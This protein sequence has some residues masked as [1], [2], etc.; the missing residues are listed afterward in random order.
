[1][2]LSREWGSEFLN[3]VET[4]RLDSSSLKI[5]PRRPLAVKKAQLFSFENAMETTLIGWGYLAN[6]EAH[7]LKTSTAII[8]DQ[9]N[10]ITKRAES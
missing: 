2:S 9:Q 5:P 7:L 8:R 6:V 1:M 4:L 10:A 3:T